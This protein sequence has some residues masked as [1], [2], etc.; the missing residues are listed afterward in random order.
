MLYFYAFFLRIYGKY[1]FFK[2]YFSKMI[3]RKHKK[4]QHKI[5]N[6]RHHFTKSC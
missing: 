5:K 4:L 2:E 3:S 6:L 1:A